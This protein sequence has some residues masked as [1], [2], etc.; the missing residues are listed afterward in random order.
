MVLS[1]DKTEEMIDILRSMQKTMVLQSSFVESM[2]LTQLDNNRDAERRR[3]EE[4]MSGDRE[5][6]QATYEGLFNKPHESAPA[7]HPGAHGK[8]EEEAKSGIYALIGALLGTGAL[9]AVVTG[10]MKGALTLAIVK[11][12]T[13]FITGFVERGLSAIDPNDIVSDGFKTGI[14][15][16]LGDAILWAGIGKAVGVVFGKRIGIMFAVGGFLYNKMG[17][18]IDQNGD[19]ITEAFGMQFDTDT[20]SGIGAAIGGALALILPSLIG[21]SLVKIF[22]GITVGSVVAGAGGGAAA[23]AATEVAKQTAKK[24][25]IG[26]VGGAVVRKIPAIAAA[27]GVSALLGG[28]E[29][30]VETEETDDVS[31]QIDSA[32]YYAENGNTAKATE[33]S[34]E[35]LRKNPTAISPELAEQSYWDGVYQDHVDSM[36]KDEYY[37]RYHL[38]KGGDLPKNGMAPKVDFREFPELAPITRNKDDDIRE[39]EKRTTENEKRR[40]AAQMIMLN[41]GGSTTKHGDNVTINNTTIV[42]DPSRSLDSSIPR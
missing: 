32:T 36:K 16:T 25:L 23:T 8:S 11:P 10:L 42:T 6:R 21:K 33:I 2:Y 9:S 18:L 19:G 35:I 4:V 22:A 41:N 15:E 40:E 37:T 14:A 20:I 28:G 1:G 17:D 29:R 5:E 12:V 3:I 30:A 7:P 31:A 24:S 27:V 34:K 13:E 39:I 38:E 26:R